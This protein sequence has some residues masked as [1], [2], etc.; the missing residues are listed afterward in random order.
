M[1]SHRVLPCCWTA[2]S[3]AVPQLWSKSAASLAIF[4]PVRM[5]GKLDVWHTQRFKRKDKFC[6]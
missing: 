4:T 6:I 2:A 1:G 3:H 5:E